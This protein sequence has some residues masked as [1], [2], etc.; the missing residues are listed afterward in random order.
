MSNLPIST[1]P[2]QAQCRSMA[3][4]IKTRLTRI[5]AAL[6][7][8]ADP[9]YSVLTAAIGLAVYYVAM[10]YFLTHGGMP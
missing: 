7:D 4:R 2:E 6:T 3:R 9:N 1:R 10:F 5:T 8:P